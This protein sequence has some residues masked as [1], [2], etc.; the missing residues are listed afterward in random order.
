MSSNGETASAGTSS[1]R[2]SAGAAVGAR[3]QRTGPE[4]QQQIARPA[5]Q[6]VERE[7]RVPVVVQPVEQ[8][9][10][11]EVQ[12]QE[13]GELIE[14]DHEARR[15]Q[16]PQRE[17]LKAAFQVTRKTREPAGRRRGGHSRRGHGTIR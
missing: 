13:R 5:E 15:P 11:G 2:V 4:G 16:P 7:R 14:A 1:A 10:H 6:A 9:P 8:R 3:H 12:Q 17:E